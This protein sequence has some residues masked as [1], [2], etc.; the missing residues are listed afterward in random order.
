MDSSDAWTRS[1]D[2]G[3]W[4]R[5][6]VFAIKHSHLASRGVHPQDIRH[7][8]HCGVWIA[9]AKVV[10]RGG[11]EV[12]GVMRDRCLRVRSGLW[13]LAIA[14]MASNVAHAASRRLNIH[15]V[16]DRL[17]LAVTRFPQV[18]LYGSIDKDAPRR[19]E[20]LVKSGRIVPGSD[21][22]LS[23]KDGDAA[24]GMA[25]G[26]LFREGGM[27]THLS[28][29][30]K[31]FPGA[32]NSKTS[33]CMDACA[34]AFFGGLYRWAPSGNDRLGL[35]VPAKGAWPAD[36]T[37]YLKAM[38]VDLGE[39]KPASPGPVLWL[40][41]DRLTRT[42]AVNNGRLPPTATYDVSTAAPTIDLR[43]VDRKGEHRLTITCRP[44][45][46]DVVAYNPVGATRARQ[47][48]ARGARSYF[49]LDGKQVLGQTD[50]VRVDG[51]DLVIERDYPP[52]DLYDLVFAGRVGAW[53][54][55]RSKAFRDGFVITPWPVHKQLTV[56]YYACWRAAPWTPR[57]KKHG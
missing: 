11:T 23:A 51:N 13:V 1:S 54:T 37:G 43:Q 30:R 24:A 35:T 9:D 29:P 27:A 5:A 10:G 48:A 3:V 57:A 26:R 14:L 47:I 28:A 20:Q 46:T 12:Q 44:G 32:R 31:T 34:Y 8:S 52:A 22:Y 19:F 38:D 18:Y 25:L 53:V 39:L 7:R 16:R 36:V 41:A 6:S 56:F 15:V 4:L 21:I 33:V 45:H 49:E 55:G 50:G 40:G 2:T 42:G 17:T